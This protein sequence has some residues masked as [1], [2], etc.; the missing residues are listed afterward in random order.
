MEPPGQI[1]HDDVCYF[2][3]VLCVLYPRHKADKAIAFYLLDY[4]SFSG[5]S[6]CGDRKKDKNK[7]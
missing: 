4:I 3:P 1:T 2:M 6:K 5:I 7:N